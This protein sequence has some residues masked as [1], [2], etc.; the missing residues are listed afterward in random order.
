MGNVAYYN[1]VFSERDELK[2]PI[3]DRALF[4][5]DAVYDMMVGETG[6]IHQANEHVDRLLQSA[7]AIELKHSYTADMI[8]EI[9]INAIQ[10]SALP[11]YTVYV[12]L[13]RN[14]SKRIHSSLSANGANLLVIVE[15]YALIKKPEGIKLITAEDKRYRYC[16]VKTVNL[17]P[18]VLASAKA[19]EADCD[20]AIFYRGQTVTECAH[21]N[22]FIIKDNILF[23][24]PLSEHILSGI[25]RRHVIIGAAELGMR[26]K[27]EPFDLSALYLADEILITSTTRLLRFATHVDGIAVGGRQPNA[28]DALHSFLLWEYQTNFHK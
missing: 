6:K 20:E 23:T 1:G 16:N 3:T 7:R 19:E 26:C 27:E 12:Q 25:T 24:H 8:Y 9:L 11:S 10:K 4:F 28:V 18:A 2:I 13:S 17:L 5:G 15:D 21:S 14:S 22:V